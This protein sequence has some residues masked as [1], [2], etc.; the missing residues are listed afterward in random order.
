MKFLD[1][2]MK[3]FRT[4]SKNKQHTDD[5]FDVF[6]SESSSSKDQ[7]GFYSF[8]SKSNQPEKSSST[9]FYD[10]KDNSYEV[11]S[12]F[13]SGNITAKENKNK[14]TFSKWI[15]SVV[16]AIEAFLLALFLHYLLSYLGAY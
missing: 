4:N 7:S 13:Y 9:S 11:N 2:L 5:L 16:Y 3:G 15:K 6:N 1:F 12:G 10:T 8:Q 14:S